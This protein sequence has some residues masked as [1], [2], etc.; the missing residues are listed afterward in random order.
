MQYVAVPSVQRI[1]RIRIVP[2]IRTADP[3][4]PAAPGRKP[5]PD[6]GPDNRQARRR[7]AA[8]ER[9]LRRRLGLPVA[10]AVPPLGE[11]HARRAATI[12]GRRRRR[13]GRFVPAV[14]P[15]V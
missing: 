12:E 7:A 15:L 5:A 9:R 13:P 11:R 8:L 6:E 1:D 10:T 3:M 14:E 4:T 2:E